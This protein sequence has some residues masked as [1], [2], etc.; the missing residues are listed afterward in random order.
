MRGAL[1]TDVAPGQVARDGV[2]LEMGAGE[3]D[4]TVWSQQIEHRPRNAR[5]R[6]L[7]DVVLVVRNHVCD[8]EIVGCGELVRRHCLAR[9]DQVVACVVETLEEILDRTVWPQPEPQP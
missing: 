5:T 3:P 6:E 4:M 2:E 8:Q 1:E 9:D 7:S